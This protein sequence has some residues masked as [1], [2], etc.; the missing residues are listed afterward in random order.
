MLSHS[1][2]TICDAVLLNSFYWRLVLN[3]VYLA[4]FEKNAPNF[5]GNMDSKKAVNSI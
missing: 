1:K 2:D 5:T 4:W 3:L